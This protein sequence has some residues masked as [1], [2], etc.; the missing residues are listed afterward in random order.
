VIDI[1]PSVQWT[2]PRVFIFFLS[3]LV[4]SPLVCYDLIINCNSSSSLV[5]SRSTRYSQSSL[6][7]ST[8]L[9]S[10]I[11]SLDSL[12]NTCCFPSSLHSLLKCSPFSS[13]FCSPVALHLALHSALHS[14]HSAFYSALFS[15]LHSSHHPPP[16]HTIFITSRHSLIT[17]I[18]PN[19]SN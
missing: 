3:F 11:A 15:A 19:H 2:W 18:T 10:L 12:I 1:K 8:S 13:S 6:I 7:H 17:H 14:F 4:A 5:K 9:T 16:H